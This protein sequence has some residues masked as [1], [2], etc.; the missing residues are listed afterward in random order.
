M[1]SDALAGRVHNL[2]AGRL[3][4]AGVDVGLWVDRFGVDRARAGGEIRLGGFV[5]DL[6][7]AARAGDLRLCQRPAK[8]IELVRIALVRVA[9]ERE[10]RHR[11][12]AALPLS[13]ALG[14]W[15]RKEDVQ[16]LGIA[17]RRGLD[18]H[19]AVAGFAHRIGPVF[20]VRA[21]ER[22]EL[23]AED[24]AAQ[25][26][27]GVAFDAPAIGCEWPAAQE[28]IDGFGMLEKLRIARP[29]FV[30]PVQFLPVAEFVADRPLVKP[31]LAQGGRGKVL[32]ID[33]AKKASAPCSPLLSYSS[34]DS[35]SNCS[36]MPK[37]RNSRS[38]PSQ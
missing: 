26:A 5:I 29:V 3:R 1:S 11:V 10:L 8:W 2:V 36:T 14:R 17:D 20:A 16:A 33:L 23:G 25:G 21:I 9:G 38:A 32:P 22:I 13:G 30:R 28:L 35:V 27:Q 12:V 15:M 19:Q 4:D 18:L 31:G 37:P 7:P 6:A 24:A 34:N